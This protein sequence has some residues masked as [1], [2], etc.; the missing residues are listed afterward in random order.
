M[1]SCWY[2]T[3]ITNHAVNYRIQKTVNKGYII[4]FYFSLAGLSPCQYLFNFGSQKFV[5]RIFK[6]FV[7]INFPE[8]LHS[9][10]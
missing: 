3:H 4:R 1:I 6:R 8:N 10:F 7:Q 2:L 9:E 5:S